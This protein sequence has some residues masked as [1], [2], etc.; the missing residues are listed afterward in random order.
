[1]MDIKFLS[2]HPCFSSVTFKSM[3]E[4]H[5][6]L[7]PPGRSNKDKPP[8]FRFNKTVLFVGILS[9]FDLYR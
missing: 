2:L 7:K 8:H 4:Q 6:C 5:Y 9:F 1:M 3:N